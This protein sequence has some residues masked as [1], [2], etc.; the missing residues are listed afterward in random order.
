MPGGP[1]NRCSPLTVGYPTSM[2]RRNV[3]VLFD[4]SVTD[5]DTLYCA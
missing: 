2:L 1:H 4:E 5:T 3:A